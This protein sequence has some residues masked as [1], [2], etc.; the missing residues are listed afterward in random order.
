MNFIDHKS[1][2]SKEIQSI[3]KAFYDTNSYSVITT[4]KDAVK[5]NTFSNEFDDIDIYYLKI[6]LEI[7]EENEISEMLNNMFEK[8]KSIKS[9]EDY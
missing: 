3:R 5:L 1:Y 4:Q 8:K 9:K 7:E 2:D 6:E